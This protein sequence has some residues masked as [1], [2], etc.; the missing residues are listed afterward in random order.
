M[1]AR[2]RFV[3]IGET[4]ARVIGQIGALETLVD[5]TDLKCSS[6]DKAVFP[7]DPLYARGLKREYR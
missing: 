4:R 2:R 7:L 3:T 5:V 1:G 6:G